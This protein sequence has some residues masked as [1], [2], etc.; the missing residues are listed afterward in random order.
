MEEAP[1]KQ[2]CSL[3]I[4]DCFA[5]EQHL[6]SEAPNLLLM[7]KPI[8][9]QDIKNYYVTYETLQIYTCKEAIFIP[10]QMCSMFLLFAKTALSLTL[11]LQ[12]EYSPYTGVTIQS[13]RASNPNTDVTVALVNLCATGIHHLL[14]QSKKLKKKRKKTESSSECRN[15]GK[16]P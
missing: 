14:N 1:K 12:S 11:N 2:G 13:Y 7:K 9:T 4:E 3:I 5:N 15:D 16:Y 10:L 6:M 8:S